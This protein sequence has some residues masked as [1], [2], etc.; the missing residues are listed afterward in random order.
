M[1]IEVKGYIVNDDEGWIYDWFGIS[2]TYPKKISEAIKKAKLSGEKIIVKINSPGGSVYAA[3]EIYTELREADCHI[4]IV[5]FCASAASFIA[6]AGTSEITPTGEIMIHRASCCASG[7]RN[8]MLHTAEIL[9]DIDS[10][11]ANAYRLK[12]GLSEDK[13]LD[14]MNH[15]TYLNA[16][17]CKE[18]GFVDSIM[19]DDKGILNVVD[20][21][22]LKQVMNAFEGCLPDELIQAIKE[23]MNKKGNHPTE[24]EDDFLIA[25]AKTKL[26]LLNL[27]GK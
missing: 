14:M 24:N 7:N 19:F 10:A 25:K 21:A 9:D 22:E 17:K 18:L 20:R 8:D 6:M 3:S 27:G 4:K 2:C 13:I 16:Q 23:K 26:N 5:G 11:I 1:E 15:E 12:T